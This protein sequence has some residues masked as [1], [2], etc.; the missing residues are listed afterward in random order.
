[1]NVHVG[2]FHVE[3]DAAIAAATEYY[4]VYGEIVTTSDL[5]VTKDQTRPDA[6]LSIEEMTK[7]VEDSKIIVPKPE[8][9]MKMAKS[10]G[11]YLVNSGKYEV[12]FKGKFLKTIVKLED[13]IKFRKEHVA[14]YEKKS[15]LEHLA[16][17]RTVDKDGDVAI[18]VGGRYSRNMMCKVDAEFWHILTY[19]TKWCATIEGYASSTVRGKCTKM[20]REVMRLIDP[21]YVSGRD[22]QVDHKNAAMKHDN[23]KCNLRICT[24][25]EQQRNKQKR[26]GCASRHIGVS[27]KRDRWRG[28]F[29]YRVD[30][31][32]KTY[33][34]H[35]LTQKECV[36]ALNKKRTEIH[37][38]RATLDTYFDT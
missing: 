3:R 30:G 9:V 5:L 35:Y 20:H 21:N 13:A 33:T 28:I 23:R 34:V 14:S 27:A 12:F 36:L 25:S 8:K 24:N 26:P 31:I 10:E 18:A 7:I 32:V 2:L 4:R 22:S 16:K 11:V 37:G 1:M 29:K 19:R 6:K 17:R 15:W 38:D